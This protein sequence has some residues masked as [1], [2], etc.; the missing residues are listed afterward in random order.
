M[1]HYGDP[2]GQR[3]DKMRT[4]NDQD[5]HTRADELLIDTLRYLAP[6]CPNPELT[7]DSIEQLIAAY[8]ACPKWYD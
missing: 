8:E 1:T 3:I 4:F 5:Y 7:I 2:L 6:M